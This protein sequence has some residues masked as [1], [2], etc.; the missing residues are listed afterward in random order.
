MTT[1]IMSDNRPQQIVDGE[2]TLTNRPVMPGDW[3]RPGDGKTLPDAVITGKG[4]TKW[5]VGG[6]IPIKPKRVSPTCLVD[7]HG[8]VVMDLKAEY[9]RLFRRDAPAW[10]K[11][12]E[13]RSGLVNS[14]EG[15]TL[16]Y[17]KVLALKPADV[18]DMTEAEAKAG[19]FGGVRDYLD[20]WIHQYDAETAE[21]M[22]FLDTPAAS[23]EVRRHAIITPHGEVYTARDFLRTREAD[24]YNAWQIRFERVKP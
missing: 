20:W 11:P 21:H 14:G 6:L 17:T 13:L 15:Y 19:G 24:K 12:L 16:L 5:K 9:E 3:F 8:K 10:A 4:V 18:R 2:K 23:P 22:A 7:K 1:L